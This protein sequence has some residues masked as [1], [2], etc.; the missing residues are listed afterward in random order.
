MWGVRD[1]KSAVV[2][3]DAPRKSAPRARPAKCSWCGSPNAVTGSDPKRCKRCVKHERTIVTAEKY[4]A[5][6]GLRPLSGSFAS[7]SPEEEQHRRSAAKARTAL[8]NVRRQPSKKKSGKSAEK[9]RSSQPEAMRTAKVPA[10]TG[11]T[12]KK[13]P[14]RKTKTTGNAVIP[15]PTDDRRLLA[16]VQ[17]RVRDEKKQGYDQTASGRAR[18]A[19][20]REMERRLQRRLANRGDNSGVT[21]RH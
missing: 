15:D 11:T 6:K 10:T 12:P 20:L 8:N 7:D 19:E 3:P 5:S 2:D 9:S 4:L 16:S 18:L 1:I 13:K 17:L 21:Y 14:T